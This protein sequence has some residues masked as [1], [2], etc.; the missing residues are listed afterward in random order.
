MEHLVALA[1][2]GVYLIVIALRNM[3]SR[4]V[5]VSG[6]YDR[7]LVATATL[8]MLAVGP[9]KLI[10]PVRAFAFWE[11]IVGAATLWCVFVVLGMMMISLV[12]RRLPRSLVVYNI[13]R[14]DLLTALKI[15]VSRLDPDAKWLG[16]CVVLPERGA[17]FCIDF[18]PWSRCGVIVAT[19]A[20]QQEVTWRE[21][22]VSLRE[23]LPVSR[24]GW[25]VAVPL[26]IA[27]VAILAWCAYCA[28]LS[29]YG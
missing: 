24:R 14:N 2:V 20:P 18:T 12:V 17:E 1:P 13:R 26:A 21:I 22:E 10:F 16:S 15:A 25:R 29:V 6:G 19:H 23:A 11:P 27:G 4:G 9:F 5:V 7:W 28:F 3:S 8:G